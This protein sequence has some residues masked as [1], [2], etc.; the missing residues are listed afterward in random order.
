LTWSLAAPEETAIVEVLMLEGRRS[1][2]S[3][4]P[5]GQGSVQPQYTAR[6][7]AKCAFPGL[8]GSESREAERSVMGIGITLRGKWQ[9]L[10]HGP[11]SRDGMRFRVGAWSVGR[12]PGGSVGLIDRGGGPTEPT[13]DRQRLKRSK[14][15]SKAHVN[16]LLP[17]GETKKVGIDESRGNPLR[18][19]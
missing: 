18:V 15:L 9:T 6:E 14:A 4:R 7:T 13:A 5:D 11:K 17:R 3:V 12:R 2:G 10:R 8:L 19:R 1:G 16:V